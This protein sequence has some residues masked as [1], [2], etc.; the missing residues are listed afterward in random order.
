[1]IS[2]IIPMYN[3]EK[4]I[5]S[6]LD[7]L[8]NQ[9]YK[10]FEVVIVNDGSKDN[11]RQIVSE[12]INKNCLNIKLIDIDNSGVSVARNV[13]LEN[14]T[15]DYISF[16]DADDI[17]L[18]FFLEL[19]YQQINKYNADMSYID[20]FS[21]TRDSNY[22]HKNNRILS[23]KVYSNYEFFYDYALRK[24]TPGIWSFLI[25][26]EFLMTN[27]I[28]FKVG[29]KYS[30]DMEFIYNLSINKPVILHIKSVQY[31]YRIHEN[32]AMSQISTR[33]VDGYNL[34]NLFSISLKQNNHQLSK[35]FEKL[36]ISRWVWSTLRQF[37]VSINNYDEFYEFSRLIDSKNKMKKLVFSKGVIVPMTALLF[38]I[39]PKI[40]F[41]AIKR[42]SRI[43]DKRRYSKVTVL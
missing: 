20:H 42:I 18:P 19:Q 10:N 21:F 30:E 29:Y 1:M 4:Y 6:L 2:I 38:L 35:P 40:Y 25:K 41:R 12:Y 39:S 3:S 37:A 9:V 11:S 23:V 17:L 31:L 16:I 26:K 13:G 24:T 7:S 8:N 27:S 34:L 28:L 15:G 5:S 14:S 33:R 43:K 32:S 36:A 22:Q